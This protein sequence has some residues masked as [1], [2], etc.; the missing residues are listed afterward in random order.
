MYVVSFGDTLAN[1]WLH[2]EL[3]PP[4]HSHISRNQNGNELLLP[5]DACRFCCEFPRCQ[6]LTLNYAAVKKNRADAA[7]DN[8]AYAHF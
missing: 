8:A 1:V 5:D 2:F 4:L 3:P 6:A 7:A